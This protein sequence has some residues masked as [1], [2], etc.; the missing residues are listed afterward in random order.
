MSRYSGLLKSGL[1]VWCVLFASFFGNLFNVGYGD[2]WFTDFQKDSAYITEKTAECKDVLTY[3]QPL[4]PS[5]GKDY[6]KTMGSGTCDPHTVQPYASQYGLQA[7][8]VAFFAPANDNKLPSYFK[9]VEIMLAALTAIVLTAFIL[10]I[11]RMYGRGVMIVSAA[12]IAISPWVVAY[13]R[14]MYWFTFLMLLPFVVSFIVYPYLDTSRKKLLFYVIIGFLLFLKS[15]DGYE[16]ITTLGI[17]VFGAVAYWE[18]VM[19]KRK[20]LE[21]WPQLLTAGGVT[22]IALVSAVV[23]NIVDL[24][25]YYGSWDKARQSVL[26]RAEDRATGIKKMQPNVI[27]G[28]E[29]TDQEVYKFIDKFYDIDKLKSGEGH[30]IKYAAVSALNYAMLPAV[31]LP[32]VL[33]QPLQAILQ[34]ILVVGIVGYL[35]IRRIGKLAKGLKE[36]YLIGLIGAL[37]WLMLMPAHAYPHAHLN[38]IIFYIPFL[39][40]CY[41]AIGIWVQRQALYIR[42]KVYGKK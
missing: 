7:R 9:R 27:G 37:S 24:H 40:V 35:C 26:S 5:A 16:H 29:L 3:R 2:G 20:L 22:V 36:L 38:G 14:N 6:M 34:S 17:S 30:P 25:S 28:F 39:L 42:K 19:N 18:M 8:V 12:L 1:L 21:L 31:S 41:V 23:V 11:G 13:A 15:L 32:F 33:A 4:I 10:K